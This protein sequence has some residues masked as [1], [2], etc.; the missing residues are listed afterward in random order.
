MALVVAPD[1]LRGLLDV[2]VESV[3]DDAT[4][5]VTGSDLA[6]SANLSRFHFDRVVAAAIGESP[7]AF[8]RRLLL[9]RAACALRLTEASVT[10]IGIEAGYEAT[11][12]FTRA[13]RSAFGVSP[14]A[15]RRSRG[16]EWRLDAPNGIHFHPPG[17]LVLPTEQ[18]STTM[19]TV[20]KLLEHDVWLIGEML[21]R[22]SQLTDAQLDEPIVLNI[23]TIDDDPT[24][25]STLGNLVW[26]KERWS[27]AIEGRTE[28]D[29]VPESIAELRGRLD[30]VGPRW[31]GL[32]ATAF[33]EGRADDAFIDATCDPPRTFT[34]AGMAA[35][36]VTFSA[37]RRLLALGALDRAGISDLGAGDPSDFVSR[38]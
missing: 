2:V 9:E 5:R 21:D 30:A 19:E 17:G 35:H 23:E 13:F 28:P 32:C 29:A 6:R 34:Y 7:V 18:R 26:Q 38:S 15:F 4:V 16:A 37:F 11:E 3:T 22:A 25:R 20:T 1:R 36:V 12:S 33:R 10:H 24:L 31:L 8:R 27:A 14:R